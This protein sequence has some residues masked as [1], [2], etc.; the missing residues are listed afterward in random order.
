MHLD[1]QKAV[2]RVGLR[3]RARQRHLKLT[4]ETANGIRVSAG[5]PVL[6]EPGVCIEDGGSRA[7]FRC[8]R[9]AL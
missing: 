3:Q 6:N 2:I 5:P 4:E 7:H 8:T 1:G 9:R